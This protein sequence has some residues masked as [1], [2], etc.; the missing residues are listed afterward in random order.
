MG[1]LNP[2]DSG[3]WFVREHKGL[4]K[5]NTS[6]SHVWGGPGARPLQKREGTGASFLY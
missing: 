2:R 4:W 6:T 1:T 3:V 5:E